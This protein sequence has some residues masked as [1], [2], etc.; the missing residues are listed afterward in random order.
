MHYEFAD[1]RCYPS[2]HDGLFGQQHDVPR[3]LFFAISISLAMIAFA[4]TAFRAIFATGNG[5]CDVFESI[6]NISRAAFDWTSRTLYY[7]VCNAQ[8]C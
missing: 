4:D 6:T 7:E 1:E 2:G 8:S 5:C 3:L